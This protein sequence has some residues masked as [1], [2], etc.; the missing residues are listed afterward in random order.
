MIRLKYI[1]AKLGK[2]IGQVIIVFDLKDLP[3]K[4]DFETITFVR[5]ISEIDQ[6]FFPETLRKLFI[7]NAP[8]YFSA[9]FALVKAFIDADTA[10]K[11]NIIGNDYLPHLL[12]LIEMDNIPIEIGGSRDDVPWCGPWTNECGCTEEQILEYL[13]K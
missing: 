6:N 7:I 10:M 2:H 4:P 11:I 8:W 5:R 3:I 1:S 13:S 9:I 12:E